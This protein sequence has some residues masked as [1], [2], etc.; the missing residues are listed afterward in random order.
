[1]RIPL[2]ANGNHLI[3]LKIYR[4]PAEKCVDAPRGAMYRASPHEVCPP[5]TH[6]SLPH[7]LVARFLWYKTLLKS[8]YFDTS[9][10]FTH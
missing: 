9:S 2:M 1:M 3:V 6:K 7:W 10:D 4:P 8:K 5:G